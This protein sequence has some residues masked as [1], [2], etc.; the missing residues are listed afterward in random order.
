[1]A[2]ASEGLGAEFG[3]RLAGHGLNLVLVARREALLRELAGEIAGAHGVEVRCAAVDLAS[4]T[5]LPAIE[6]ATAGLEVGLLVYNA[7]LSVIGPFLDH[8]LGRHRTELD[9]NC[10]RP[11]ELCHRFGSAMRE[12]GRGGL[13][14]MSSLAGGQGSPYI[15]NYGATKAWNRVFAEALWFELRG[16]GVDVLACCAGA[17]RTP[18][19]L[20]DRG[21]ERSGYVPEQE[22]EEV[23]AEALAALGRRPSMIPGRANRL[24]SFFMQRLLPRRTAITVMGRASRTVGVE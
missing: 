13:L 3:R 6:E 11:L 5:A 21:E 24:A 8:P 9:V 2:G 12:R 22:P 1:V 18:G 20:A 16:Q 10:R 14:L 23:V 19:Y 17:T 4:E 7:A 15:A